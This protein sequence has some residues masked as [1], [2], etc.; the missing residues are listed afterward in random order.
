MLNNKGQKL[1]T[2]SY[3]LGGDPSVGTGNFTVTW[4]AQN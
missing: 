1:A 4:K 2:N 3:P